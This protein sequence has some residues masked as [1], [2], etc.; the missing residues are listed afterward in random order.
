MNCTIIQSNS[1]LDE[2]ILLFYWQMNDNDAM[3]VHQ[4][5]YKLLRKNLC[6]VGQIGNWVDANQGNG[7]F[8]TEQVI[9]EYKVSPILENKMKIDWNQ[10]FKGSTR[11]FN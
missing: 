4:L 5:S 10:E 2:S 1:T 6:I 7:K 11:L 3:T 8:R 9:Y